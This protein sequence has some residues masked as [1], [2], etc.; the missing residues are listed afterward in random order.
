MGVN[1]DY[2]FQLMEGDL[3]ILLAAF[4]RSVGV[5]TTKQLMQEKKLDSGA[6][7]FIQML[8][9]ALIAGSWLLTS[10]HGFSV[11]SHMSFWL[12][13][14]YLALFC[15]L[16]AFYLQTH[17]IRETSPTHVILI[18]GTEPIFGALFAIILLQEALTF[19][20]LIGGSLIIVA[21]YWGIIHQQKHKITAPNE[22]I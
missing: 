14:L 20:Q 10:K 1:D 4:L 2:H 7:T 3:I 8:V 16:L 13:T 11:P 22:Q 15:T 18:M 17:M 21:T 6:V 12:V 19:I 9:V 5:I